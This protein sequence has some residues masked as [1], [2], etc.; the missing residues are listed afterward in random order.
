MD[1]HAGVLAATDSPRFAFVGS[2]LDPRDGEESTLETTN[3]LVKSWIFQGYESQKS[4]GESLSPWKRDHKRN[5]PR[6]P[7]G[8]EGRTFPGSEI[9]SISSKM[10]PDPE[11][12]KKVEILAR[13]NEKPAAGDFKLTGEQKNSSSA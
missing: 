4:N 8:F 6:G 1:H 7:A 11:K 9:F 3:H 13:M 10:E 2:F 12:I 5:L